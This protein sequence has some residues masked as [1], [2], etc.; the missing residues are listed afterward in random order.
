MDKR[1]RDFLRD[2]TALSGAALVS[3]TPAASAARP[4]PPAQRADPNRAESA[5]QM[6]VGAARRDRDRAATSHPANGDE[7]RYPTR[8]ATFSKGLPHNELG[9]VDLPSYR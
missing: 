1:R 3:R 5:Y 2:L 9:E 6:R 4:L 7:D 8:F